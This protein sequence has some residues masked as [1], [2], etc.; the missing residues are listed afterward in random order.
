M[1]EEEKLKMFIEAVD[2][3]MY[4]VPTPPGITNINNQVLET[5]DKHSKDR[6]MI[7]VLLTASYCG[8]DE[9]KCTNLHPCDECLKMSNI[10]FIDKRAITRGGNIG[11]FEYTKELIQNKER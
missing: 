8:E 7:S 1:N 9:D 10:V 6:M 4:S 3:A 11:G 2:D 5:I